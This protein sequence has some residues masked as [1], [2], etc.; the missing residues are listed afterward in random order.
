MPDSMPGIGITPME[1]IAVY[2]DQMMAEKG[3][4]A[5]EQ[6]AMRSGL[7]E[8][9]TNFVEQR[10][11]WALDDERLMELEKMTENGVSDAELGEFFGESG[12]DFARVTEQAMTE[13]REA[14]LNSGMG[15]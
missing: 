4:G 1:A 5:E 6:G 14:F 8:Q 10:T 13:F 11:L 7:I 3:L 9:A 15:E 2:V 12:V